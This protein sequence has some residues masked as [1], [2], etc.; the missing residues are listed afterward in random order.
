MAFPQTSSKLLSSSS[1]L[2]RRVELPCFRFLY[3]KIFP[4]RSIVTL[5]QP[6][7]RDFADDV[8]PSH[9]PIRFS[10]F[11]VEA[12][13]RILAAV[14]F[15]LQTAIFSGSAIAINMIFAVAIRVFFRPIPVPLSWSTHRPQYLPSFSVSF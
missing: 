5:T 15:Q 3:Q 7:F 11:P 1:L 6:F 8:P 2:K 9:L 14:A 4:N 12:T 10:L 13:L